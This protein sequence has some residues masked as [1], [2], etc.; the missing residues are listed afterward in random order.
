MN[1]PLYLPETRKFKTLHSIPKDSKE[2]TIFKNYIEI[3]EILFQKQSITESTETLYNKIDLILKQNENKEILFSYLIDLLI[4]YILIRPKTK[5]FSGFLIS[6]LL[7]SYENQRNYIIQKIRLNENYKNSNLIKDFLSSQVDQEKM[8][9]FV[10]AKQEDFPFIANDDVNE[11][12]EYI[13]SHNDISTD[14]GFYFNSKSPFHILS[15]G[16]N[17][18]LLDICCFY[19]SLECFNFLYINKFEHGDKIN[20]ISIFGGNLSI[21]HE[22]EENGISFDYC[23]LYSI[24][25]H[26]KEIT[27]WLLSNY[28]CEIFPVTKSL[29]YYDY[30][31]F[32]FLL[33]NGIDIN[34]GKLTPLEYFIMHGEFD[35]EII[36]LLINYGIDLNKWSNKRYT[37][38]G[39]LCQQSGVKSELIKVLIE[40]GAN[41]EKGNYDSICYYTPLSYLCRKEDTNIETMKLLLEHGANVNKGSFDSR[42]GT[43]CTPLGYL[44]Q[45][46]VFNIEA[47]KFL[48]DNGADPN[49]GK[50]TKRYN[51]NITPLGF[52]CEQKEV[53]IEAIKLLIQLGADVNKTFNYGSY[54]FSP[55][56]CLCIQEQI[57]NEAIKF[58]IENKADVNI[59]FY[60]INGITTP[61]GCLCR[62]EPIH[63]E[64]IKLLIN[65]GADPNKGSITPLS[66][67]CKH[68]EVNIEAISFLIKNNADVNLGNIKP[69]EFL[70]MTKDVNI[71]AF[72]LLRENGAF[73]TEKVQYH[74]K[75]KRNQKLLSFLQ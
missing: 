63:F 13:N 43:L 25:Y 48:I 74:I 30:L 12:K 8:P 23:F 6:K 31:T 18:K 26:Q 50:E 22:V 32:I 38:L 17:I 10:E 9:K 14:S 54:I 37:P 35:I 44:C 69:L 71:E 5:D 24:K 19:G 21:I 70:C 33:F 27:E 20:E 75:K 42:E 7:S 4:Y 36:N 61:L 73:I 29:E 52:L 72:K 64:T 65:Y 58:L 39:Y 2:Y 28:K 55:L 40:N 45:N 57:S 60:E 3:E 53:N 66:Y 67:L 46:K 15:R 68:K 59:E 62:Q 34:Q 51:V 16:L 49:Q 41:V 56:C 47:I 11:L 1:Q